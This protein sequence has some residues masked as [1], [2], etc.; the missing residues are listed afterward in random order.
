VHNSRRPL[1]RL[2]LTLTL[3][4]TF[5]LLVIGVRGIVM[6]Y[7]CAKFG[8]FSFSHFV[9]IARTDRESCM[10]VGVSN[11]VMRVDWILLPFVIVGFLHSKGKGKDAVLLPDPVQGHW[12]RRWI[13]IG[14]TTES[15]THGQCDARPTVI[16]P[17]NG[18]YQLILLGEQRHIECEQLAQSRYVKRSGR[19]RNLRPLGCKSDTLTTP[20]PHHS[21]V[22]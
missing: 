10:I 15:V 8:D 3:T 22:F 16:F 12:A 7:P 21:G 4:L 18:R 14:Y 17:A 19:D 6:D 20:P 9:F 2:T 5:D 11:N 1:N 13:P